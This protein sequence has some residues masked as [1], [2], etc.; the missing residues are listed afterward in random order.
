MAGTY[1]WYAAKDVMM[2]CPALIGIS[3][4]VSPVVD[5]IGWESGR[6]SSFEEVFCF[7][8]VRSLKILISCPSNRAATL[9]VLVSRVA[10]VLPFP[11]VMS[12]T[13]ELDGTF[14]C[15]DFW[16]RSSLGIVVLEAAKK[17]V[18]SH[19]QNGRES[20]YEAIDGMY[21]DRFLR[22]PRSRKS[23]WLH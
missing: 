2:T 15:E 11:D 9:L 20:H 1:R 16:E 17:I 14:E 4:I 19:L 21:R 6:T 7:G 23:A 8:L 13:F 10:L 18:Q 22:T 5:T 3:V 12:D